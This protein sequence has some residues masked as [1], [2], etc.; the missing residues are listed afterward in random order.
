MPV[1]K[2]KPDGLILSGDLTFN[3]KKK[4]HEE[5]AEKLKKLRKMG[6][7]S[8]EYPEIMI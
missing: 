4:S 6:Y 5:L 2:Q 1:I 3:G 7:L 8:W